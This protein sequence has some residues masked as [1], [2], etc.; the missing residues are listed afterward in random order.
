MPHALI[1]KRNPESTG[2]IAAFVARE[3]LSVCVADNIRDA[4]NCFESKC[5]RIVLLDIVLIDGE[6]FDLFQTI[7]SDPN[8]EVVL[9]T[10]IGDGV[11]DFQALHLT[12]S[13]NKLNPIDHSQLSLLLARVRRRAGIGAESG[14]G[15][16]GGDEPVRGTE[17]RVLSC[18]PFASVE[19]EGHF[20]ALYGRS[21]AMR[22]VYEQIANVAKTAM[23]VLIV[24]ESG[25]GKEL[26]AQGIHSLSRRHRNKFVAVNCGAIS[27][28]LIESE[29]F[30]HEKGSFTGATRTHRGFFERADEGTLFLDEVTEMSQDLQVKF[31]RVLETGRFMRVGSSEL[32]ETDARIIAATN[33]M[34]DRAVS[35]GK[36]RADLY[37]RLSVFPILLP[38]LRERREDIP[39]LVEHF[40]GQLCAREKSEKRLSANALE[41]MCRYSWPGNVRELKNAIEREFVMARGDEIDGEWFGDGRETWDAWNAEEP[42]GSIESTDSIESAE[43]AVRNDKPLLEEVERTVILTTL[44]HFGGHRENAAAALGVS[45]KTLYNRLKKYAEPTEVAV[46]DVE[47]SE[48]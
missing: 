43:F 7:S 9:L 18:C 32:L 16:G 27:S 10:G 19:H 48:E 42:A 45:P 12:A 34:P 31:L 37:Y 23:T 2:N 5:P 44:K 46:S 41:R 13:D 30:G 8:T 38:P 26:V 20:G 6:G 11:H 24:G 29:I 39:L 33:V 4:R 35:S 25:T 22:H 28:Q 14:E 17:K 36:L 3:G 40:L 1:V 21:P 47:H 15:G